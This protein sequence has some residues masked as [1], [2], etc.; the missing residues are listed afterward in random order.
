MEQEI[1]P[2]KAPGFSV[3]ILRTHG[4]LGSLE[5]GLSDCIDV[6]KCWNHT[7]LDVAGPGRFGGHGVREEV[8]ASALVRVHLPIA[9]NKRFRMTPA[10]YADSHA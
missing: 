6:H 2:V 9:G 10:F 1:S 4:D 3:G 8:T 5:G 7:D